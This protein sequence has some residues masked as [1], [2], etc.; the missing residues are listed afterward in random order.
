V[1]PT[2]IRALLAYDGALARGALAFLL[3]REPDISMVAQVG[4]GSDVEDEV[5][6]HR[7]DVAVVDFGLLGADG[8]PVAW[9][10]HHRQPGAALV[11][12]LDRGQ[13]PALGHAMEA[14]LP[15]TGFLTKDRPPERL[16][17]AVRAVVDGDSVR[18]TGVPADGA[19]SPLT[20]REREVLWAAALGR[21]VREIAAMLSLSTGT[22]HNHLSRIITK[23][24]SHNRLEAVRVAREA[25]WI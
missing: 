3:T 19:E 24:G 7:P 2:V 12:L 22:V 20:V 8:A 6:R 10:L 14:N 1:T 17:A 15:R 4:R 11:V 16:A 9:A 5:R 13:T 18:D 23:T 25:G 21:P